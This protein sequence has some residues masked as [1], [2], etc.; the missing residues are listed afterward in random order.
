VFIGPN[1]IPML[2]HH[3]DHPQISQQSLHC[4]PR[5]VHCRP[6]LSPH[7]HHSPTSVR[8]PPAYPS[9]PPVQ[10]ITLIITNTV[11]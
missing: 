9:H 8:G 4:A 10:I 5:T 2:H 6:D 1:P 11:R 3:H 7:R